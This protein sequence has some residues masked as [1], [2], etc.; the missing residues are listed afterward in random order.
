MMFVVGNHKN[1]QTNLF[2][3]GLNASN[4][5]QLYLP[6]ASFSCFQKGVSYS[7]MKIFISYQKYK[8]C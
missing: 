4:K 7:A 6:I 5:D 3:H 2:V 8:E 1:F